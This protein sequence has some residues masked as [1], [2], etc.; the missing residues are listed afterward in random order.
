MVVLFLLLLCA[1]QATRWF[2]EIDPSFDVF[3]H[4]RL[5]L[6]LGVGAFG[7]GLLMPRARFLTGI[8]I[9]IVGLVA[10][11][12]YPQVHSEA[13]QVVAEAPAGTRALNVMSFNMSLAN[14][15]G[16]LVLAEIE[17][18]NPD[19][20]TLIEIS[21][22]QQEL[23]RKLREAYPFSATCLD[24][25]GCYFAMF[26]RYAFSTG[27][28]RT[29][30]KTPRL[31]SARF[32]Q[33]LGNLT[34]LGVHVL[35][36]PHSRNQLMQMRALAVALEPIA[37]P[38]IVMGDFNATAFSNALQSFEAQSRL[39]RHSGLPSWPSTMRLPQI[40][41][42][43]VFASRDIVRLS[44]ARIGRYAGSDHYSVDVK[45]AVPVR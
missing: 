5:Q 21:P 39:Q 7:I 44:T 33:E 31:L 18:V 16:D 42:D 22:D 3:S 35:R 14:R 8:V 9:L 23:L 6:M 28:V 41:I 1:G 15:R 11:G 10:I 24:R 40:G 45:L 17:R 2:P 27:V 30:W 20:V 4:F 34:L 13:R 25:P 36:F 26:S 29:N 32:G 19:V 12:L 37:G 43:H 38:K